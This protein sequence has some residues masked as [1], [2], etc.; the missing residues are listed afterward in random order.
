MTEKTDWGKHAAIAAYISIPVA[1]ALV[2]AQQIWPPD[3]TH[4]LKLDFLFK[5]ITVP[6]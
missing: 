4:P 6:L 2:L 1:I 5:K 3:P